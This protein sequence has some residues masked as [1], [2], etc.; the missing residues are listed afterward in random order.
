MFYFERP[1]NSLKLSKIYEVLITVKSLRTTDRYSRREHELPTLQ[2]LP[3]ANQLPALRC[4]CP[5]RGFNNSQER[6]T[7][8]LSVRICFIVPHDN[9]AARTWCKAA[10][11]Y[12]PCLKEVNKGSECV[13]TENH[14]TGLG[15][16]WF[17]SQNSFLFLHHHQEEECIY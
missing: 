5:A 14:P 2:L 13:K 15:L 12:Q 1:L 4:D 8:I 6:L 9:T 3:S 16:D 10:T 17:E 11:S 7:Q